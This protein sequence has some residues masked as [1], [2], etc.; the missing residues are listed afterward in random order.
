MDMKVIKQRLK[1]KEREEKGERFGV[2]DSM[3]GAR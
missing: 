2:G 3:N 1:R